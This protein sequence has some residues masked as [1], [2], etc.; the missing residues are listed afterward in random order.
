VKAIA[1][2]TPNIAWAKWNTTNKFDRNG[3][4]TSSATPQ[5]AAA[6]LLWMQTNGSGY[7]GWQR[8]EAT[9]WALFVSADKSRPESAM[10]FGNGLL[11]AADALGKSPEKSE[12]K[13]RPEDEVIFPFWRILFG[14]GEPKEGE[15]R[16]YEVEALNIVMRSPALAGYTD[17]FLD[18]RSEN[19]TE[20]DRY[21]AAKKIYEDKRASK[22]L[23][24]YLEVKILGKK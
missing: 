11:R 13:K 17:D 12:L 14:L 21:T 22:A 5:V 19:I 7:P 23:K 24:T 8:V 18:Y 4:G 10:Y 15:E 16:M 1:A 6:A 2:F 20:G 3:A 9:R